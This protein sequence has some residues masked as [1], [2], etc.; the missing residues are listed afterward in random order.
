MFAVT[1]IYIETKIIDPLGHN[2]PLNFDSTMM[3]CIFKF[4]GCS[5]L[6]L[7]TFYRFNIPSV[8][9]NPIFMFYVK[10]YD[11]FNVVLE[12]CHYPLVLQF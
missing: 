6:R 1:N 2:H 7:F 4:I 10:F 11:I 9:L 3:I 8:I 5:Y 12:I